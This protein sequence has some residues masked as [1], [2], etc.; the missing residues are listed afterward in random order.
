MSHIIPLTSSAE[1]SRVLDH[2]D[3]VLSDCDGVL[4]LSKTRIPGTEDTIRKLRERGKKVLFVINNGAVSRKTAVAKLNG[5]GFEASFRDIF[6][7]S[8]VVA[9]YLKSKNFDGKV[10]LA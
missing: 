7:P 9:Q 4:Y 1:V 3:F 6:T 2:V 5:L 8:F 10:S